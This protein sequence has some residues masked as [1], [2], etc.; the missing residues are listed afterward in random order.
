MKK[1]IIFPLALLAAFGL[2][3]LTMSFVNTDD[4]EK[5]KT[6]KPLILGA[7]SMSL[8]VKDLQKSKVFYEALGFSKMGGDEKNNYLILKNGS[9]IIGIFSGFFEGN[10]LTF[11]PG[12]DENGKNMKKWD[13]VRVIQQHLK[14]KGINIMTET[15]STTEGP[16]FFMVQDPDGNILLFDQHR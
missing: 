11:N 14:S 15:D 16:A 8:N 1:S 12:W 3:S 2:G 9:T 10:M 6:E 5:S 7:F 13:D 4:N